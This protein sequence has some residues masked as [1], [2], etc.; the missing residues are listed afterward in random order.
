MWREESSWTDVPKGC[1]LGYDPP[2]SRTLLVAWQRFP[3]RRVWPRGMNAMESRKVMEIARCGAETRSGGRCGKTA[4]WGTGHAGI[5]SCKLHG[6]STPNHELAAA[7][8]IARRETAKHAIP[9][10]LDPH[11]AILQMVRLAAGWVRYAQDRI[12]ELEQRELIGPQVSTRPLKLE[13]G[14]EHPEARV[15]E[16]GPPAVHIWLRVQAEWGDRLVQYSKTAIACGI[17]ERQVRVAEGQAQ[18]IAS[19]AKALMQDLGVDPASEQA[20]GLMRKH[21]TLIAGGRAA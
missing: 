10:D 17:A 19:F 13:K 16:H 8:E 15:E 7:V 14:A 1:R 21:L 18:L 5:G 4:G 6:G 9:L 20:R 11:D 12:D 3:A 2:G